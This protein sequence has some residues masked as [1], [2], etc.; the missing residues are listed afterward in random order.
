MI[1]GYVRSL[2]TTG[3]GKK[4]RDYVRQQRSEWDI[5]TLRSVAWDCH[6]LQAYDLATTLFLEI[7][8]QEKSNMKF[9]TALEK[10]ADR[11]GRLEDLIAHYEAH[12]ADDKRLYGRMKKLQHRM[13]S[14]TRGKN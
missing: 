3:Q 10:A 4:A 5:R 9:L 11:C 6:H 7:F 14:T 12:A 13:R 2:L 1:P 8:L